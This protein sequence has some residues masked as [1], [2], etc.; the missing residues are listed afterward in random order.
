MKKILIRA[1][2]G[3][4]IGMGHVMRMLVLANELKKR[5]EV[6]FL[7]IN[8]DNDKYLAGIKKIKENGFI[9]ELINEDN[10]ISEIIRIQQKQKADVLIT[11][12]YDVDE[13]Y[14]D[15]LEPYFDK[16]AYIDDNNI[17]RIN[18][19]IIIN[20]NINANE[21][22][23]N[24]YPNKKTK[25]LLGSKYILLR[26]EFR[27]Q[28]KKKVKLEVK[29]IIVTVGGMDDNGLTLKVIEAL[30]DFKGNLHVIIGGAFEEKLIENILKFKSN[31][32]K[33]IPY[34]NAVMSEVMEKCDLAISGCGSTL[35][36]LCALGI[37]TIGIVIADNQK[38]IAE[39]MD[40]KHAII[41][42]NN[43]IYEDS[44]MFRQIVFNVIY[45]VDIRKNLVK[46]SRKCISINGAKSLCEE[47]LL[48]IS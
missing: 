15:E 20:Q 35:Y 18:A 33:I 28:S 38:K 41:N 34:E 9:V 30:T 21:Y 32:L 26:D 37:P 44:T 47:I 6:I 4:G 22:K 7:C 14:F 11:D 16:T 45:N 13:H 25:F 46:E 23:Y 3:K 40:G 1:D 36:E 43:I 24:T 8:N 12:S 42:T 48:I 27:K 17:C 2:G 19:D 10:I 31:E 5:C 29:D 39:F